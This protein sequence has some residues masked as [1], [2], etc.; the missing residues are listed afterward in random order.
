MTLLDREV[1]FLMLQFLN[2][3]NEAKY[4]DTV[5]KLEK[6]SGYFFNMRYFEDC[7][8]NGEWDE[9]D[10]YLSGFCKVDE[11]RYSTKIFFE[12]RK[13]KYFEALGRHD[14]ARAVEILQKD[15]K[16]FSTIDEERF[17]EMTLLLSLG[18]FR[19]VGYFFCD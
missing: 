13:Q 4:K 12:I 9:A 19:C 15:L 2:E 16:V 11:S 14:Y 6:D 10:S 18:N 17:K 3:A 8:N 7:V 5:H 1:V